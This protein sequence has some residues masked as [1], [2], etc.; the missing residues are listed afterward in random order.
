MGKVTRREWYE[1]V[2]AL[3][4]PHMPLP[5]LTGEEAITATRKLYRFVYGKP[6]PYPITVTSGN[7]YTR[8][9]YACVRPSG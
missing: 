7:R 2:E 3:W 6:F 5:K 1:R 4:G 9:R 8:M